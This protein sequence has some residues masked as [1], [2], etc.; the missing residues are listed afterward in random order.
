MTAVLQA[1]KHF[2]GDVGRI[3]RLHV[4]Y[5]RPTL[6]IRAMAGS[7]SLPSHHTVKSRSTPRADPCSTFRGR[8]EVN[9]LSIGFDPTIE[10][11]ANPRRWPEGAAGG[12]SQR[13][14]TYEDQGS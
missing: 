2:P 5:M 13:Q 3:H 10:E 14:P 9:A 12:Q 4:H 11:R 6:A 8:C 1:A 7:A